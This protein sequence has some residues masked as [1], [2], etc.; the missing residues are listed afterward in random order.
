MSAQ[1]TMIRAREILHC[2]PRRLIQKRFQVAPEEE[3]Q[4]IKGRTV[5][6]CPAATPREV[7]NWLTCRFLQPYYGSKSQQSFAHSPSL[8]HRPPDG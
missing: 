8:S 6:H 1:R 5:R 7:G 2:S 4:G 3:I